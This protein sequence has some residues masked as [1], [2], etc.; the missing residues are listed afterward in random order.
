MRRNK[1]DID[2][3]HYPREGIDDVCKI[4][5]DA[6]NARDRGIGMNTLFVN[7]RYALSKESDMV[8][9]SGMQD[10]IYKILNDANE[11]RSMDKY[12][13]F[14]R[15][16]SVINERYVITKTRTGFM[17]KCLLLSESW[18]DNREELDKLIKDIFKI[19]IK[20]I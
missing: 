1:N 3:E 13:P 17:E 2:Y 11:S 6:N 19:E 18:S 8:M 16:V 14:V 12:M 20:E 10:V 9:T 4:I 7:Y 5:L 15:F